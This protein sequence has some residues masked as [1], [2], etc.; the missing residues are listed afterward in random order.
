MVVYR[1]KVYLNSVAKYGYSKSGNIIKGYI[2]GASDKSANLGTGDKRLG[3]SG[4]CAILDVLLGGGRCVFKLGVSACNKV[5][6]IEDNL[7][8]NRNV[9]SEGAHLEN[10][11][12]VSAFSSMVI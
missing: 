1:I 9:R 11:L 8:N 2:E 7:V 6:R 5:C 10:G 4:G 12:A 3:S